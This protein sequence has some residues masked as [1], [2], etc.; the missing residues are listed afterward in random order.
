MF[1]HKFVPGILDRIK[2]ELGKDFKP[3]YKKPMLDLLQKR[4]S[5]QTVNYALKTILLSKPVALLLHN[6]LAHAADYTRLMPLNGELARKR[7]PF[8]ATELA[9]AE[10][11]VGDKY[12][13]FIMPIDTKTAP[14]EAPIVPDSAF[15]AYEH[16]LKRIWYTTRIFYPEVEYNVEMYKCAR[17]GAPANE[18]YHKWVKEEDRIS[19]R[20]VEWLEGDMDVDEALEE[21]KWPEAK[22]TCEQTIWNTMEFAGPEDA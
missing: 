8:T 22:V 10:S 15:A 5:K 16:S 1:R 9:A 18:T 11:I 6:D 7:F 13:N 14:G 21:G 2:F 4:E 3:L 12:A 19:E 20:V 17:E